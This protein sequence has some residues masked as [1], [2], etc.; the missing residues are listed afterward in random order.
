[1]KKLD[2]KKK[3]VSVLTDQEMQS[4]NGGGT[5]SYTNCTAFLCCSPKPCVP[6]SEGVGTT[7]LLNYSCDPAKCG[8]GPYDPTHPSVGKLC[9][10]PF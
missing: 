2:L 9:I 5:T 7:C 10:T 4:I 1:M 3:V 8:V 6:A